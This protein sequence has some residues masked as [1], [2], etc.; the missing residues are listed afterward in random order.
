[1]TH[2]LRPGSWSSGPPKGNPQSPVYNSGD[3]VLFTFARQSPGVI[4]ISKALF[5]DG[6]S[7]AYRAFFALPDT[8]AT[9]EGQPTNAVLGFTQMLLRILDEQKP[10]YLAVAFDKGKPTFRIDEFAAYKAHRK[11]TPDKLVPQFPLIKEFVG[12]LGA[13]ILEVEGWEG[14][15]IL[16]ALTDTARSAGVETLILTGDRDALQL[17]GPGVRA[18]ITLRGISETTEFDAAAVKARYGVEP[19]KLPDL[20]GLVGDPSD[21]LPGVPGIGPKTAVGLLERFGSLD[22]LLARADEVTPDRVREAL[23]TY[24]DDARVCRSLATIRHEVPFETA[25][26]LDSF[27]YRGPDRDRLAEFLRRLEFRSLLKR[28]GL[29]EKAAGVGLFDVALPGV[30]GGTLGGSAPAGAARAEGRS[31]PIIRGRKL[32]QTREELAA[33]APSLARVSRLSL[34]VALAGERPLEAGLAG[35]AIAADGLPETL[36][37]PAK[38]AAPSAQPS[39]LPNLV[40]TPGLSFDDLRDTLG[41]I[42]AATEPA[43]VIHGA[44]PLRV[45]L[46]A[47][48]QALDGLAMDT[49][50]GA[51]LLDPSRARYGLESLCRELVGQDILLPDKAPEGW[52]SPRPGLDWPAERLCLQADMTLALA[53]PMRAELEDKDLAE[54]LDDVE[55][56]LE[57]V[58]ARMELVGVGIDL[59][60]LREIS[61]ELGGRIEELAAEIYVLAAEEFNINSP[62]QLGDI[63][64]GK[65]K[66]PT[67]HK[68][69]T[70]AYS[71]NAEVLEELAVS[72]EI[73]AK[74]LQHRQLSKLKGTY[75]DGMAA[76]VNPAT[77]RL[78]TV[79]KQTVTATG[80]LSSAEPNLQ[81]IPIREEEGRR[82]RRVFVAKPGSV[83]LAGDYSQIE[84]R[85]MAHLSGDQGFIEA[86]RHGED[87]HQRTASEIFG[88]PMDEVTPQLRGRAKAVNFGIIYGV[89]DFGLARSTGVGR[90]EAGAYIQGYFDRYP[91]I[92][93][94][95]D[96]TLAE[97]RS[98]GFV[99]TLYG[100]RRYLPELHSA[101][102]VQRQMAERAARNAPL[103]GTAADIIKVAMVRIDREMRERRMASRMILQ[104]HDELLFEAPE[105]EIEP[106]GELV[107]ARMQGVISLDVPLDVD[108]K[109][110]RNW[111]EMKKIG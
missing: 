76:L 40:P 61:A 102:R 25:P 90:E 80:R 24:A 3:R 59:R 75:T 1:M 92:R 23:K 55:M 105:A 13:P 87:I 100:R 46:A 33:A 39:L 60:A 36:Y 82:I 64:F 57:D 88:V 94:W 93:A 81:N 34:A 68:T 29:T 95:V 62:K 85:L 16:A 22:N 49:E 104:V 53:D 20:K 79:F 78:H 45:W 58:L 2:R 72:H 43:K 89:S 21:N 10:D 7:L 35:L 27:R 65:L 91:G 12:A 41:P 73:V 50:L 74:I 37:V 54:L 4:D 52:Q 8:L 109:V 110:G 106:L 31:R 38:A 83:L 99:S 84:L 26:T 66:L 97:A 70:G 44:K 18:I 17:V 69:A 11:P 108:L 67:G 30:S 19:G 56:P 103:Q 5:V 86:F 111:Y 107:K 28:L 51:Y 42:L 9:A 48:G 14:D 63:L 96:K 71:T 101:N 47:K 32:V 6:H 77:D 15:D 98:R